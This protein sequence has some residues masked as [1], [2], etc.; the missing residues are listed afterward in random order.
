MKHDCAQ[1][2]PLGFSELSA[3]HLAAM[4]TVTDRSVRTRIIL[5]ILGLVG[6]LAGGFGQDPKKRAPIGSAA[7][8]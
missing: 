7:K 1:P 4:H 2:L 5:V 3:T 8:D 6:D